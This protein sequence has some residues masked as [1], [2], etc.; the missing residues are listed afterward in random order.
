MRTHTLDVAGGSIAYDDRGKGP[1][2]VCA[3]GLGDVRAEYRFLAPRLEHA[4]FRVVT[5]DLRG[6]GESSVGWPDYSQAAVGADIVAL[7]RGLDAGPATI[8][9]NSY[10][11][12]AAVCAAAKAPELVS[13]LV[14][15]DAFVRS[16]G[17]SRLTTALY[18]LIFSRPWGVAAWKMYYPRLYPARK[19]A[20]FGP[21]LSALAANLR[22]R[23]RLQAMRAMM[24]SISPRTEAALERV[25][26]PTLVMMGARDPDFKPPESE[27]HWIADRLHG[28]VAMIADA[29][30]YPHAEAPEA[31]AAA[32]LAFLRPLVEENG[33]HGN[34]RGAE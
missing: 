29:G 33:T 31:A 9:G 21:Y 18:G 34:A 26:A 8:I 14:L 19:P 20:D 3:P 5:M 17:S 10:A 23:G 30:H 24:T 16:H 15:I 28:E 2:V 11:G 6:H 22:E 32:I 7:I 13:R 25:V 4:G 27:A 1:L 12:G